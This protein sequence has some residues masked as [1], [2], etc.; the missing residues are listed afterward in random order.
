MS[1]KS[2][3]V[4]Y[5]AITLVIGII[6]GVLLNRAIVQKRIKD[7]LVMRSAGL[8]NPRAERILK[9]TSPEQGV[10]IQAALDEH[11]RRLSEI[12][13]RFRRE[14]DSAF[15][16]LKSAMDPILTPE[17]KKQLEKMIPGPPP[18]F[19][20]PPG[21]FPPMRNAF[22]AE[23]ELAALKTELNLS[24]GQAK[25]IKAF[26]EEFETQMKTL[27][28]KGISPEDFDSRRKIEEKKDQEIE[29]IL[30]DDQKQKYE[31]I[32]NRGFKRPQWP[33]SPP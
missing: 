10:R 17:Q 29:K 11:A 27:F 16:S 20:R 13:E 30:T 28:K 22:S 19:G 21:G 23:F 5:V 32:K 31:Q 2:K 8:L 9:P 4:F 26:L 3:I 24:E 33:I 12:H 14:I 18:M 7:M 6:I 1:V 15:K 25:K